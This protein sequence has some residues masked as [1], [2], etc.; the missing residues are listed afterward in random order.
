MD[1]YDKPRHDLGRKAS[2]NIS[3]KFPKPQISDHI[4]NPMVASQDPRAGEAPSL[5]NCRIAINDSIFTV[6]G[7][8]LHF[9]LQREA[10]S[11]PVQPGT[12]PLVIEKCLAEVEARG[13]TEV[14][15]CE[16]P[17]PP[18]FTLTELLSRSN[19]GCCVGDQCSKRCFQSR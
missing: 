16:D 4:H 11:E 19:R 15:I 10:G 1:R 8:E 17:T 3:W 7:V 5:F 9:L 12:I 14:G 6:F 13:L 2:S 18:S